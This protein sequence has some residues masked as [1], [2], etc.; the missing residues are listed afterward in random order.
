MAIIN[1]PGGTHITYLENDAQQWVVMIGYNSQAQF[2]LKVRDIDLDN[3]TGLGAWE[4]LD[5]F[6]EYQQAYT[7]M[8]DAYN[9]ANGH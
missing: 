8:L 1:I 3:G 5:Q 4:V 9:K 2:V 6:E 7:A